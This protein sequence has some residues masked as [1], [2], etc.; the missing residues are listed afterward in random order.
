MNN[1]KWSRR[2]GETRAALGAI[3]QWKV[4]RVGFTRPTKLVRQKFAGARL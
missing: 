1:A 4:K 3:E 2:A